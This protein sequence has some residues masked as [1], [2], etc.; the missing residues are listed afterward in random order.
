MLSISWD[1]YVRIIIH[2]WISIYEGGCIY[3]S[4]IIYAWCFASVSYSHTGY[5][6]LYNVNF[7]FESSACQTLF[8]VIYSDF[9]WL[10]F[11]FFNNKV[12]S[13]GEA[14]PQVQVLLKSH[15]GTEWLAQLLF[16]RLTDLRICESGILCKVPHRGWL[17][18]RV[19]SSIGN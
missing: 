16:R 13:K 3:I 7:L 17:R 15:G 10:C 6:Y 9:P 2:V 8:F 4:I 12:W 14:A 18:W 1:E 5:L 11:L 19:F